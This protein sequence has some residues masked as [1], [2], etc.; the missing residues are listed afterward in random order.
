MNFSRE[1]SYKKGF[2]YAVVIEMDYKVHGNG[3]K[4]PMPKTF[5]Q[6]RPFTKHN[7]EY[8]PGFSFSGNIL[9]DLTWTLPMINHI[10]KVFEQKFAENRL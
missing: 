2:A 7:V 5:Q 8:Y 9:S 4:E 6:H 3:V 1:L 10:T